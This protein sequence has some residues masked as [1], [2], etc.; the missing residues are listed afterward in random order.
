[1]KKIYNLK[2]IS[3]RIRQQLKQEFPSYKF[4]VSK[5]SGAINLNIMSGPKKLTR[6]FDELSEHTIW[7]YTNETA[8]RSVEE[9]KSLTEEN[10]SQ[11]SEHMNDDWEEDTWNNGCF[12]TEEAHNFLRRVVEIANQWNWDNSDIM[13]DYFDVNYYL[14][15]GIGK[16]DKPYIVS[17]M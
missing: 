3:K 11:I 1:M 2:E 7:R 4:S 8:N 16:W 12:L 15:L 13:T 17:S 5:D 10:H 14:H 9:L 6:S